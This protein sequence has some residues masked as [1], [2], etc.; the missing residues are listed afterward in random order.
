MKQA[1]TRSGR[2]V[3][4]GDANAS[5]AYFCPD[6]RGRVNL[7]R[8]DTQ[9]PHFRHAVHEASTD[10]RHYV[11][12]V[13]GQGGGGGRRH[14][15]AVED[16]AAEPGLGMDVDGENQWSLF[17]RVPEIPSH[18]F[19]SASL[20]SLQSAFVRLRAGVVEVERMS[21]LEIRPGIG[22]ARIAVPPCAQ[23]YQLSPDGVWPVGI[24]TDRWRSWARGVERRGT[25]FR[26]HDGEWLRIRQGSTLEWGEQL[27]LV[28]ETTIEP[29][30]ACA[31]LKLAS[32]T[33][34]GV[35]WSAFQIALPRARDER[36]E[37]WFSSLG[38]ELGEPNW[39][40]AIA[41]VPNAID[42]NGL[43][44][45]STADPIIGSIRSPAP[46][47]G[48][49]AHIIGEHTQDSAAI[50]ADD[51]GRVFVKCTVRAPGRYALAAGDQ[52]DSK[53][54]FSVSQ[55]WT[56]D[57]IRV[58]IGQAPRLLVRIGD[59]TVEGWGTRVEIGPDVDRGS[60]SITT[61]HGILD[62]RVSFSWLE[63]TRRRHGSELLANAA[64][65]LRLLL[66]DEAVHRVRLD[67]GGL[68]N[69]VL[70][71]RTA[72]RRE[73]LPTTSRIAAWQD[74]R[75]GSTPMAGAPTSSRLLAYRSVVETQRQPPS[76]VGLL[77]ARARGPR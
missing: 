73:N 49:L 5:E 55:P 75:L 59:A 58:A 46:Q 68:G 53:F 64:E 29:P 56:L 31:S 76:A 11:Y 71:V 70:D 34:A 27:H 28:A 48:T 4:A 8:G 40:V 6:C 54:D 50:R 44:Q 7:T 74:T 37:Q 36:A 24:P 77:R 30:P 57:G 22:I 12:G 21:G 65:R 3:H 14:V 45:F 63:E 23:V 66:A 25:V 10:C 35:T 15:V 19:G 43:A 61:S 39:L 26:L 52:V 1:V 17:I 2:V 18:L 13:G 41:T 51:H 60:I 72:Q 42:G 33:F 16:V 38:I 67:G 32:K 69:I 62:C 9:V 20:K 47:L